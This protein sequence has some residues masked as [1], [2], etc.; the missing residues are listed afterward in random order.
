VLYSVQDIVFTSGSDTLCEIGRDDGFECPQRRMVTMV[1]IAH[2]SGERR[3]VL[4]NNVRRAH[5]TSALLLR[6][7]SRAR[8]EK[9]R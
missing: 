4:D 3:T 5:C 1:A 2:P 9:G 7:R 6:T 8:A